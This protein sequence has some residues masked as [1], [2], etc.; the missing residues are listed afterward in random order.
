MAKK[1]TR[2]DSGP[3]ESR[4]TTTVKMYADL[5]RMA[6]TVASHLDQDLTDFLDSVMRPAILRAHKEMGREIAEDD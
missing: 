4:P 2:P 6:R 3:G 1:A 5:H